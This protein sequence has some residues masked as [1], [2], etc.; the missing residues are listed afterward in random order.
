M[1]VQV[2]VVVIGGNSKVHGYEQDT[3][4]GPSQKVVIIYI[5]RL[6]DWSDPG[7]YVLLKPNPGGILNGNGKT[8]PA[9]TM[10]SVVSATPA[11]WVWPFVSVIC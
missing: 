8:A 11:G 9:G 10:V 6:L 5:V 7:V 3:V 2:E 4:W 1:G